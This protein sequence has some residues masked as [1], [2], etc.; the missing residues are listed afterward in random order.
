[1]KNVSLKKLFFALFSI[2]ETT[3]RGKR[4]KRVDLGS[5]AKWM[6]IIKVAPTAMPAYEN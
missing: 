6:R 2:I 4:W 3:E 5:H 1:M